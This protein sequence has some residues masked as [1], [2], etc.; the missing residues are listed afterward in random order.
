MV[1]NA[2]P[3]ATDAQEPRKLMA[4]PVWPQRTCN[5]LCECGHVECSVQARTEG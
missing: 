1:T 3:T 5:V 4:T 2:S